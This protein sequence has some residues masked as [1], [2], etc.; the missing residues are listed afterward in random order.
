MR[1]PR[2]ATFAALYAYVPI[3][4]SGVDRHS[5]HRQVKLVTP[6]RTQMTWGAFTSPPCP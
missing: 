1:V 3:S 6:S 4:G 5:S 2:P